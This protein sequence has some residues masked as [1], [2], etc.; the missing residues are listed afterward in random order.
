MKV[1]KTFLDKKNDEYK[2][3]WSKKNPNMKR[4]NDLTTRVKNSKSKMKGAK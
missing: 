1:K 4:D 2:K 3:K